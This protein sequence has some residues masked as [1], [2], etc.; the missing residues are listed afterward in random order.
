MQSQQKQ[1][2]AL[3]VCIARNNHLI[4]AGVYG[5]PAASSSDA[6]QIA[7]LWALKTH[8]WL[9]C[10]VL[11]SAE[12]CLWLFKRSGSIHVSQIMTDPIRSNLKDSTKSSLTDLNKQER[13]ITGS[14]AFKLG[15]NDHCPLACM[16]TTRMEKLH[17]L[18]RWA[19]LLEWPSGRLHLCYWKSPRCWPILEVLDKH[20][21][22][23]N[24]DYRICP[25]PC[26]QR[27]NTKNQTEN[28]PD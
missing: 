2:L 20:A 9:Y 26:S 28:K 21:P 23:K 15:F 13:T 24:I 10:V 8:W 5:P 1:A 3:K 14:G 25:A 6:D 22:F 7:D 12:F 19:G 11:T 17:I 18:I 4:V 27:W 16:R